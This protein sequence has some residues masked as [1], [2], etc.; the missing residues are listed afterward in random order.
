VSI[1]R[2][3]VGRLVVGR[4]EARQGLPGGD[5]LCWEVI[6]PQEWCLAHHKGEVPRHVIFVAA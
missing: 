6:E 2:K 3:I 1:A 5:A 4:E